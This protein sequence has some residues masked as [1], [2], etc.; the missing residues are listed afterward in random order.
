[1]YS[2]V[3]GISISPWEGIFEDDFPFPQVGYVSFLDG[4]YKMETPTTNPLGCASMSSIIEIYPLFI[5]L[6][7]SR[8]F[9]FTKDFLVGSNLK[10][11]LTSVDLFS[12][13]VFS[14][15]ELGF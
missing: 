14:V 6:Y 15:L 7:F 9:T 1:M 4:M 13:H 2:T 10:V 12:H 3:R 5:W 11:I 8:G